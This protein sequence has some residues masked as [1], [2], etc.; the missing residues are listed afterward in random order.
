[1]SSYKSFDI[2]QHYWSMNVVCTVRYLLN[3]STAV[4]FL[5][6]HFRFNRLIMRFRT[7]CVI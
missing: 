6:M 2:G 5:Q 7:N 3:C 4:L 1:M